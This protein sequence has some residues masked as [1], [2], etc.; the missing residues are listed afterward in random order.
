M[1]KEEEE[2]GVG[3]VGMVELRVDPVDLGG[4]ATMRVAVVLLKGCLGLSGVEDGAVVAGRGGKVARWWGLQ[5]GDVA[6]AVGAA[7]TCGRLVTGPVG[8]KECRCGLLRGC[9]VSTGVAGG[10]N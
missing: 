6:A 7:D 8:L 4:V 2:V 5:G 1:R 10:V 9:F 3:V